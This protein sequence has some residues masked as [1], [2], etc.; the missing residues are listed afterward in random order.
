MTTLVPHGIWNWW[1]FLV[2]ASLFV[3][4]AGLVLGNRFR[5]DRRRRLQ[6][7]FENIRRDQGTFANGRR[8]RLREALDHAPLSALRYLVTERSVS[9]GLRSDVCQSL[10]DR[11][12]E[13]RILRDAKSGGRRKDGWRRIVA[14]HILAH[15]R[16]V[17]SLEHLQRALI[18][19]G[20][21]VVAE[22]ITLLGRIPDPGAAAVLAQAL[23]AG[24]T[25]RSRIATSL[26]AFP[27]DVADSVVPMLTSREPA[28]RYWGA[29][30]MRRYAGQP[31]LASAM[32][33]YAGQSELASQLEIL[34]RD[35]D[36]SVRRAAVETIAAVGGSKAV[37]A[38]Q[39]LLSDAVPFVRAHA[40][41]TLGVLGARDTVHAVLPLLADQ[42]WWVRYAAK[43]S[44]EAMGLAIVDAIVP[45]LSHSDA[46]A[47][48]GA[49]EVLQN[50]GAFERLLIEEAHTS[51][52]PS[53]LAT[54]GLLARAG[55]APMWDSVLTRLDTAA[56]SRA[57]QVLAG[58]ELNTT[59]ADP[60][61]A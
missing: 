57:R 7:R 30:L 46:F 56:Q 54:L 27:L 55:G 42:D 4:T 23:T 35:P 22:T 8:A 14:L 49:A 48:N 10:M 50:L 18:D 15:A 24:I 60:G 1:A 19:G 52:D 51:P 25:T 47:R 36:P 41:R 16:P 29:L 31:G 44:L 13:Q 39:A 3:F 59:H 28:V 32:R 9:P 40:A 12:G 21:T 2:T 5:H 58:I 6:D 11:L 17:E 45:Y 43:H 53:R 20:P 33:R 37:T 34:T 38:A 26:D 61:S